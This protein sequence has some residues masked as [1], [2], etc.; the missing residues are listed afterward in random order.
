MTTSQIKTASF[1]FLSAISAMVAAVTPQVDLLPAGWRPYISGA[2]LALSIIGVGFAAFN[3]SLNTSH[4][5]LPREDV[6]ALPLAEKKELGVVDS[7][8]KMNQ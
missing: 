6:E 1:S 4:V 3:Q 5:S 7:K 8:G 2:G